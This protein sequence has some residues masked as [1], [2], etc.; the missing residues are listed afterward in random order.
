VGA[1]G[2]LWAFD[3]ARVV[4]GDVGRRVVADVDAQQDPGAD[5][6]VV[7][8]SCALPVRLT[9]GAA[10]AVAGYVGEAP[11]GDPRIFVNTCGGSVRQLESAPSTTARVTEPTAAAATPAAEADGPPAGWVWGI[12][13]AGT[14]ALGVAS[15]FVLRA[16]RSAS[17]P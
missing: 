4:R 2:Q 14:V 16:R 8:S 15:L 1:L 10:Y 12:S 13:G 3:V 6:L 17:S 11:D 5:G 9:A 7:Q